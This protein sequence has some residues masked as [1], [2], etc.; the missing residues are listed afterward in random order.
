MFI[1]KLAKLGERFVQLDLLRSRDARIRHHPV[2]YEMTLEKSLGE[3]ER[4]RPRK[5]Q[6]LSLLNFFLS[7][8]VE[9][10]HSIGVRKSGR[11]IVAVPARVSNQAR[12]TGPNWLQTATF[13][14]F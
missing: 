11:R 8:R 3:P 1:E 2:R 4:L 5:K 10:V 9:F 7:L 14:R 12:C 13:D 6:L